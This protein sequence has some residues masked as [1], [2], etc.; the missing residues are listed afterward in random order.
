[1]LIPLPRPIL[2]IRQFGKPQAFFIGTIPYFQHSTTTVA[3][4]A[5]SAITDGS[6][7]AV[8]ADVGNSTPCASR[9][10]RTRAPYDCEVDV[11]W[12]VASRPRQVIKFCDDCYLYQLRMRMAERNSRV[13]PER[14]KDV[15]GFDRN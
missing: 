13:G 5:C 8:E 7:F 6:S 10:D 11:L 4:L 15:S 14:H 1:M 12:D 3:L 9:N 2:K